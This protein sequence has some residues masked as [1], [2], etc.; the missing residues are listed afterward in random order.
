MI[1]IDGTEGDGMGML[2]RIG[3]TGWGATGLA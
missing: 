2:S 3:V 1:E